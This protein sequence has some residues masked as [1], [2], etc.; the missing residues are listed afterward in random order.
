MFK[1][2]FFGTAGSPLSSPSRNFF[3]GVEEVKL[4]GLG[5]MELEFVRQVFIKEADTAEFKRASERNNVLLTCH[6][7]YYIN[8]SSNEKEKQ[9]AS[10]HRIYHSAKIASLCG[11][12][13]VTF[14][15]GYFQK[16]DSE[17]VYQTISSNLEQVK[18]K[19][20]SDGFKIMLRPETTG[21][22]SQFGS[23][24]ELIRLCKELNIL[25]CVDFAH[26]H[27]RE[28][29]M[30]TYNEFC[31][32]LELLDGELKCLQ[33]M[34]IHMSGIEYTAKGERN[35]LFLEESDFNWR[36]L[37]KA[38]KEFN[39]KGIV[40]SESPNIEKDALLMKEYYESL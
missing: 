5:A 16:N 18:Q 29:K 34:H 12:Q 14:H 13:S 33:D 40:I 2:L 4:L 23:L 38:W 30:N 15:A 35:H 28:G 19:L 8:L 24:A 3:D 22:S 31:S 37:L 32:V 10:M 21:K 26:L 11:A 7:P 17:D 27:A 20:D 25:P 6:A 1:K 9:A 36:D 39:I